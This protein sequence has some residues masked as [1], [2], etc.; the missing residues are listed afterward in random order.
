MRHAIQSL[1]TP[2]HLALT[3][4]L[5]SCHSSPFAF[6]LLRCLLAAAF[7]RLASI[8][9]MARI[10]SLGPS[11]VTRSHSIPFGHSS[12]TH[13]QQRCNVVALNWCTV[14]RV[15]TGGAEGNYQVFSHA[16]QRPWPRA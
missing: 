7:T 14:A 13:S 11:G 10:G 9:K 2:F 8:L 4:N 15:R 5:V 6:S 1:G 12:R 3:Y 16:Q